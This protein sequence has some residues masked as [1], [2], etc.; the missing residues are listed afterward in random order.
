VPAL[1][2]FASTS[3]AGVATASAAPSRESWTTPPLIL[4]VTPAGSSDM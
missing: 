2:A 4:T 3:P 1:P